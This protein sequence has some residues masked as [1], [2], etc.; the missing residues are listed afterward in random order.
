MAR[1]IAETKW[2][3]GQQARRLDR[4]RKHRSDR[5]EASQQRLVSALK[6]VARGDIP[7]DLIGDYLEELDVLKRMNSGELYLGL[8]EVLDRL[9]SDPLPSFSELRS[10][11]EENV[12]RVRVTDD[13][14]AVHI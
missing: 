3:A 11:V 10:I 7:L 14:V 8:P 5:V 12:V 1:R 4:V 9:E 13:G 2:D 6:R